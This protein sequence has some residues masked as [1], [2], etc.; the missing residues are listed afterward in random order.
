MNPNNN[1]WYCYDSVHILFFL[2]FHP[3]DLISFIIALKILRQS[4]Q[5]IFFLLQYK[6]YFIWSIL[7]WVQVNFAS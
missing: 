2:Y 5:M 3:N 4:P 1:T 6:F 7:I